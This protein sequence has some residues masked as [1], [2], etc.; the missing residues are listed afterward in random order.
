LQEKVHLG[1][2]NALRDWG[3][4][5]DYVAAMWLMLQHHEPG[6]FVIATG[7]SHSVRE[8]VERAFH[9]VGISIIWQGK[10][11]DEKGI[12]AENGRELVVIDPRYFRPT[13]V[14]RLQGDA[15]RAAE[16]LGWRPKVTFSELVRRMV[17]A[18]LREAHKEQICRSNGF[19]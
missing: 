2:L 19:R 1:N 14:D 4:A 5:G 3:Y 18:D 16:L 6:D 10:G 15:S 12:D 9:E 13:E 8:F 7:E 17:I 11:I